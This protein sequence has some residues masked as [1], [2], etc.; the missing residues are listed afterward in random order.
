[1]ILDSELQML[2]DSLAA[3]VGRSIAIDDRDFQLLAYSSHR[4]AL[5]SVRMASI[6]HRQ[7]PQAVKEWLAELHISRAQGPTR[8]PANPSLEMDARVCIPVRSQHRLLGYIWIIDADGSIDADMLDQLASGSTAAAD[9]LLRSEQSRDAAL[10]RQRELEGELLSPTPAIRDRAAQALL[11][12]QIVT[13]MRAIAVLVV[14]SDP[15]ELIATHERSAVSLAEALARVR[16]TLPP[17]QA[18]TFVKDEHGVAIACSEPSALPPG[19]LPALA[20]HL[21]IEAANA[22][23]LDLAHVLIGVSADHS[24]LCDAHVGW[25]EANAALTC[26]AAV[27][28]FNPVAFWTKLGTYRALL[29]IPPNELPLEDLHE[30]LPRFLEAAAPDLVRTL[31]VYLDLAGDAQATVQEL[32]VHRASLYYRLKRIEELIG[33]SLRNGEVRLAFGLGLKLAR[34]QGVFP[35]QN[36]TAVAAAAASEPKP[37]E[38]S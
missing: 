23:Q 2:A 14:G 12:E 22:L 18:L 10:S 35:D 33:A 1:V 27:Q 25:S 6:L 34:L 29:R 5:D 9:I 16:R 26:A 21:R 13:R 20:E 30:A 3:T 32:H 37:R 17:R 38:A 36:S 28:E 31:D 7:A 15:P 4:Q 24:S 8:V 19:G 11:D